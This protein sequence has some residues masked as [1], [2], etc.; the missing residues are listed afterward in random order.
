MRRLCAALVTVGVPFNAFAETAPIGKVLSMVS[1]LQATLI[2]EGEK[3]QREYA[4]FA[5]GCEDRSRILGFEL[6]TDTGEVERLQAAIAEEAATL[7]S[8]K[9][10]VAELGAALAANFADLKAAS[11]VR[12]KEA[13][14]FSAE[15]Q[16]VM[17]TIDTLGRASSILEREVNKGSSSLLQ[18]RNAG[19]LADTFNVLVRASMIGTSEAAKLASLVQDAQR[20]KQADE[21]QAPGA[22]AAAVYES[23][24][25]GTVDKTCEGDGKIRGSPSQA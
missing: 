10:K 17:E 8:L 15:E 1:D 2:H 5:A 9:T 13:A 19:N 4:E 20:A 23:Q 18:S 12:S 24:S 11:A 14:D 3:V 7:G 22:P 25:G 21:D 6:Q 16:E